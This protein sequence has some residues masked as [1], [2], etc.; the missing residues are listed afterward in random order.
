MA[1][2]VPPVLQGIFP[3]IPLWMP[4]CVCG[5]C[6]SAC[7]SASGEHLA[8]RMRGAAIWR[9]LWERCCVVVWICPLAP[10]TT[11]DVLV[12]DRG[13][14]QPATGHFTDDEVGANYVVLLIVLGLWE[15]G[16]F[17][18]VLW[19]KHLLSEGAIWAGVTK[20][21]VPGVFA[22]TAART[23]LAQVLPSGVPC[24]K[25][26]MCP[27]VCSSQCSSS[28]FPSC[29]RSSFAIDRGVLR[30]LLCSP[31]PQVW[32]HVGPACFATPHPV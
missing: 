17:I 14:P 3:S 24:F 4:L 18:Q 25:T 10:G 30:P 2:P 11:A 8:Q 12:W 26:S 27:S 9:H 5:P 7:L 15:G 22:V 31:C 23:A 21:D 29:G 32:N 20:Q 16:V 6:F 13:G 1:C 28:V 19:P